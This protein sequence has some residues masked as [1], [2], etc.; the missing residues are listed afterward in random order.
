MKSSLEIAEALYQA[1]R[2]DTP[3]KTPETLEDL[4]P[5]TQRRYLLYAETIRELLGDN[6][7]LDKL[8][9]ELAWKLLHPQQFSEGAREAFAAYE[10]EV[11][12]AN[13]SEEVRTAMA[14]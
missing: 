10:K 2:E 1:A 9:E 13:V 14:I 7:L 4:A 8:A 12:A 11:G 5:H 3:S 6:G